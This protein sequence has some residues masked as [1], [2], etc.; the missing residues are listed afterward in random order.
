MEQTQRLELKN[1]ALLEKISSLTT[2]Y[3]NQIADLRV[4]MTVLSQDLNSTREELLSVGTRL[5]EA[6]A[7]ANAVS[8]E[9]APA[10]EQE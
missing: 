1:Q 8:E 9:E 2:N 5:A 10:D 3:E 7:A 6:E 4:E